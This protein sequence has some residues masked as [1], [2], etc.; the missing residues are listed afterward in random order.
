MGTFDNRSCLRVDSVS[1]MRKAYY[2]WS[3][4][5]R[6]WECK[7]DSE[8][9]SV[10]TSVMNDFLTEPETDFLH[11]MVRVDGQL[12]YFEWNPECRWAA[13]DM[14]GWGVNLDS[15]GSRIHLEARIM[16]QIIF[17]PMDSSWVHVH[18]HNHAIPI[19]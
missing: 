4:H 19:L 6:R 12:Q 14:F 5:S 8:M 2:E 3:R 10:A 1:L 15:N 9:D 13:M 16:R 11:D 18:Q 17:R 7:S